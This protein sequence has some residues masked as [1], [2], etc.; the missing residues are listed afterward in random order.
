MH[1]WSFLLNTLLNWI[2]DRQI[3]LLHFIQ[4]YLEMTSIFV[5]LWV[6]LIGL[7]LKLQEVCVDAYND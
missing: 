4:W 5:K 1:A 2:S 7:N 6:W 3:T